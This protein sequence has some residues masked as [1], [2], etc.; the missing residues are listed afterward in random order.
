MNSPIESVGAIAVDRAARSLGQIIYNELLADVSEDGV[1]VCWTAILRVLEGM[2]K[3][4][5]VPPTNRV[6]HGNA[7]DE[8]GG[9]GVAFQSGRVKHSLIEP[10]RIVE[11]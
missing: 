5:L 6:A 9:N 7:S 8:T 3:G 1:E 2:S 4:C 10:V 11:P